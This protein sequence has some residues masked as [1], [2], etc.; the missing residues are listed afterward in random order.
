MVMIVNIW[1]KMMQY[2]FEIKDLVTHTIFPSTP[3]INIDR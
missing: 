1:E 3:S 2:F